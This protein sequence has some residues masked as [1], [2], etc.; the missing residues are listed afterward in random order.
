[1]TNYWPI[2]FPLL[3][4]QAAT[5]QDMLKGTVKDEQGRPIT[6]ANLVLRENEN[7]PIKAFSITDT[8]GQF[9]LKL[10]SGVDSVWLT[11]THIAYAKQQLQVKSS[12]PALDIVLAPE[13]YE[14]PELVVKNDPVIRQGDTL[15]F[16]VNHYRQASDQNIEQVLSNIPGITIESNG[17]IKYDGLDISRFYIEGLD[18]LEG[19]YRIVTRNLN[20]DAIRDVE[21]IE[22]HQPIRALDS[23][24]RPDNAAINLR[25]KSGMA[26][27]G[28]GRGGTGAAPALYLARGD[29]F[30]FTKQQ[31]F[32]VLAAANNTGEQQYADF[33]DLYH[34]PGSMEPDLITV[35]QLL[36][37]VTLEKDKYLMNRE[38]TGGFNFLKKL[39][40]T[41]QLKWQGVIRGDRINN[42]GTRSLQYDD[43]EN[44][45][46]FNEQLSVQRKP[47]DLEHRII[48]EL[49]A[50]KLYFRLDNRTAFHLKDFFA[51]NR[52]NGTP[53]PEQLEQ[54]KLENIA[55]LTTIIRH[56]DKAYKIYTNFTY[57]KNDDD[58]YLAPVDIFTADTSFV[59]Y[60][61][62]NQTAFQKRFKT[63]TYT[64]FFFR[65]KRFSG[66]INPGFSYHNR[67]LQTDLL[68]RRDSSAT[69]T[70]GTD[71][72]ND[73]QV[74]EVLPYIHQVYELL[75]KLFTWKLHLPLSLSR[76][77][78][79]NK[80]NNVQ[81]T[82]NV[83]IFRPEL[84][85]LWKL[86]QQKSLNMGY[87]FQWDYDS[88]SNL[89]YESYILRSN[90]NLSTALFD[91]NRYARQQLY[92]RFS[93]KNAGTSNYYALSATLSDTR[94]DF[95]SRNNFNQTGLVSELIKD[96]N[97]VKRLS[98]AGEWSTVLGP[99]LQF[100]S[101]TQ[102][103]LTSR[104]SILNGKR[105]GINGHL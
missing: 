3:L 96:N 53:F 66:Q 76:L 11:I 33:Q 71:F 98:L 61:E 92:T 88:F 43:G 72:Q 89:F 87:T 13:E 83:R 10:P 100:N 99:A 42:L 77:T 84:S 23:L 62:A 54:Q 101:R 103:H 22:H 97:R 28:S 1:M 46:L 58:L 81:R 37:P 85:G 91:I 48:Y 69:T 20:I 95:L 31:Q 104:Q 47:L 78:I 67:V 50:K 102:Y 34:T 17:Q 40:E 16:D 68:G 51:D 93:S 90:R 52:V 4:L 30:G 55:E 39:S 6:D 18:M 74:V 2:I 56:K 64:N 73:N 36:P 45:F 82:F 75:Y 7:S 35:N 38:A 94:F 25:L 79:E 44:T 60:P 32:N 8:A 80:S 65:S 105:I 9:T 63:D 70:L 29:V 26:L 57:L 86:S 41:A 14:L 27:T 5:A 49:N 59:R 19:R 12:L 21:I 15:I 24:V